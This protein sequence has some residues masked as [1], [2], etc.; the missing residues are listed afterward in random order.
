MLRKAASAQHR[1]ILSRLKWNRSFCATLRTLDSRLNRP[2]DALLA[3]RLA[4]LAMLGLV[5]ESLVLKELLFGR[6]EEE[7]RA[8]VKTTQ[9]FVDKIHGPS[10]NPRTLDLRP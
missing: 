5:L 3:L 7:R 1:P 10:I 4:L 6:R 2:H 9:F 8:A